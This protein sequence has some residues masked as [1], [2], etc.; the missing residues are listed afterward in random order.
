[1]LDLYTYTSF[2]FMA[3]IFLRQI[4]IYK[5]PDKINYA[6]LLLGIGAIASIIHFIISP[7]TQDL[8]FTF[9]SALI[10]FLVSLMLFIVANILHQSQTVQNERIK[11]EFIQALIE[12]IA[13]LKSFTANL[14]ERMNE[15][16][17]NETTLRQEFIANFNRDIETLAKLLE[18]Q[19]TFMKNFEETKKWHA[20]LS[21]L[22]INFTEFKLPE[23]DSIVH[24]HIDMLRISEAEHYEKL[25][26]FLHETLGNKDEIK[27]EMQTLKER[28]QTLS[29]LKEQIAQEIIK[30]V[31]H[32]FAKTSEN[33]QKEF[34]HLMTSAQMLQTLLKE[35]EKRLIDIKMQT[36][37]VLEETSLL[38]ERFESF[39]KEKALFESER[40]KV[41]LLLEKMQ[42]FHTTSLQTLHTLTTMT[43]EQHKRQQ[44]Q[45]EQ[46][47]SDMERFFEQIEEKL[48]LN[49]PLSENISENLKLLAKKTQ[50]SKGGYTPS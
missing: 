5:K 30:N 38:F 16:A 13:Q 14:E 42:T 17:Q 24:K 29:T 44:E 32:T 15:Y 36:K 28:I 40:Q 43:Q 37:S 7:E 9:K 31:S 50:M 21:E 26:R 47:R 49:T 12:Q 48:Q 23:L 25:S 11:T 33:L 8:L 3:L 34:T 41:S 20:Q 46:F 6:P 10:P 45:L 1:M 39:E 22:F 19:K 4:S 18:N 35:D 27:K 2:I